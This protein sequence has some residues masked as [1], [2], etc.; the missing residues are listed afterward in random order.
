MTFGCVIFVKV[1]RRKA[2]AIQDNWKNRSIHKSNIPAYRYTATL[3]VKKNS[4]AEQNQANRRQVGVS[5]H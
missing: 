1:L 4:N 3:I 5:L 2:A